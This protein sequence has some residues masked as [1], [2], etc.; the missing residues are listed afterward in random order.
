MRVFEKKLFSYF[1]VNCQQFHIIKNVTKHVLINNVWPKFE[2]KIGLF[3]CG[4]KCG[5]NGASVATFVATLVFTLG[6][7]VLEH[8]LKYQLKKIEKF[9]T[10]HLLNL[11]LKKWCMYIL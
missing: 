2:T 10:W 9:G 11:E 1:K 4:K 3:L 7:A 5:D 8:N 6:T